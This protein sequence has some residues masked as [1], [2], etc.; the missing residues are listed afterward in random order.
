MLF[1]HR[2][3]LDMKAAIR[4]VNDKNFIFYFINLS[5]NY[6]TEITEVLFLLYKIREKLSDTPRHELRP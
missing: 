4:I 6:D 2:N 1:A 5:V 3:P